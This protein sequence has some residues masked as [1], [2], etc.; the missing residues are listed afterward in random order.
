MAR[1]FRYYEKKRGN[2]RTG[3]PALAKY[4]EAAFFAVLLLLGGGGLALLFDALVVPQWRLNHEFVATTCKVIEK[5]VVE[6]PAADGPSF[7]P[8]MR[9]AYEVEGQL[10]S[11]DWHYD[12]RKEYRGSRESAE[13]I[14]AQ[15]PLWD[16]AKKNTVPCWYDPLDP[17]TAVVMRQSNWWVW[18]IFTVPGSFIIIGAGGLVYT[19]LNWGKSA[20]R[21]ALL[22]RRS[23]ERDLFGRSQEQDEY[24]A[25]PRGVDL[26]NS[27]G[28]RLR[29]RLPM[30]NSP[31][32][33][34]V[35]A[36]VFCLIWNGIV[37]AFVV[38]AVRGHRDGQ[39]DWFLTVLLVPFLMIGLGAIF[40][41]LRQL[42]L[43]TGVG[44]TLVEISDHP[45]RRG[46]GYQIFLSQA[47]ML[48]VNCL[49]LSLTCEESAT[50]CQGTNTRTE[51]R[52]VYRKTLFE[53]KEIK[54]EPGIPLEV[55]LSLCVPE[56]AM[57]SF[58][59]EHNEINWMLVI[60]GELANWPRYRRAFPVVV[61]PG[62]RQS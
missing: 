20:E 51:T 50:Y 30:S 61:C 12:L 18:L 40:F 42:L 4:G 44:P 32:W 36:L 33:A 59:A 14:L 10:Y 35:G 29:Y 5:R 57:H 21:R 17:K 11:D 47:G 8:E 26:T 53:R 9:I 7:R 55:D 13:A 60:E 3:S 27:P 52:E 25:V 62:E 46:E 31:G 28:T 43:T 54:I 39:P 16:A 2:R 45:L 56:G 22:S 41:F 15:F 48:A 58:A 23:Q 49:R 34:L 1:A 38:V 24:P 19:I 6:E 37:A